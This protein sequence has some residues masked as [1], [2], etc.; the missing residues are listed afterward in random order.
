LAAVLERITYANEET[1]YTIARVATDRSGA[2]LLIRGGCAA[3]GV[4]GGEPAV[5]RPTGI[6][7]QVWAAV[8][9]RV[10]HD[11]VAGHDPAVYLVAFHRA[12]TLLTLL[13]VAT[14]PADRMPGIATADWGKTLAWLRARTGAE[15]AAEQEQAVR[16]IRGN[17]PIKRQLPAPGVPLSGLILQPVPP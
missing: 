15:L 1:G 16:L 5:G 17:G 8:R 12:E 10:V 6:A 2:D 4:A 3:G 9:S 14:T 11:G 13:R 7:P